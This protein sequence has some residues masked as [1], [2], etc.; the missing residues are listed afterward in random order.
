MANYVF[1]D[2]FILVNAVNWSTAIKKV[3]LNVTVVDQKNTAFGATYDSRLGGLKDGKV[4]LQ[5]N[6]DFA[7]AGLDATIWAL[8]GTVTTFEVRATSAARS[9]SNAAYTGS[10][11]V[12]DWSPLDGAV[13][14]LADLT[15]TWPTSGTVLRQTS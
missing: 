13:G 4:S 1:T 9:T 6:Q 3:T 11:L 15:I 10:V 5:F 8:L 12:N 2:G 7:A 14:D